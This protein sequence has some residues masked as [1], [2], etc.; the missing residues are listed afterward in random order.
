[1][2]D[3]VTNNG[4]CTGAFDSSDLGEWYETD[5]SVRAGEISFAT[6]EIIERTASGTDISIDPSADLK[7]F[8][9]PVLSVASSSNGGKTVGVISVAPAVVMGK[10]F[11]DGS[12]HP[13]VLALS[14]R[15]PV[16]ITQENGDIA[17]GDPITVSNTE[18]GKGMKATTAGKIIGFAAEPY[19]STHDLD[20]GMIELNIGVQDWIPPSSYVQIG[21]MYSKILSITEL[22]RDNLIAWFGSAAN[23]LGDF[24][25]ARG[26]FADQLC[27]GTRCMT[28]EHFGLLAVWRG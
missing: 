9:Q 26:H 25:A 13:K 2:G 23:G 14:G 17:V 11:K 12:V 24:F 27:V 15:V 4:G 16:K 10:I 20:D 28:P 7:V 22:F 1:M 5:G 21:Q 19:D 8:K 3:L 6:N 18:P